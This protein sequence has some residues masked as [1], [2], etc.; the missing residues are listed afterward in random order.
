[1]MIFTIDEQNNITAFASQE[2]AAAATTTPFH[3]FSSQPE[4][5]QLA[6]DWTGDRLVEIWNSLPGVTAVTKFKD[7]K[8]AITRIWKAIEHLGDPAQPESEQKA[9]RSARAANGASSKAK[10]AKKTSPA[11][12]AS[13]GQKKA[14]AGVRQ[15]SK[16]PQVIALLERAKGATLVQLMEATGWQAHSVRGFM[17]GAMKKAGYAVES[18]KPEGGERTYRINQ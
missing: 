4:L 5:A 17:A 12:K 1:M 2:E 7:R 9:K 18:F 13:K 3:S 16:T 15:G 10:S 6:V 14:A 11:K 8:T